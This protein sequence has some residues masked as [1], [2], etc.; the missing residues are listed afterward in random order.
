MV[1]EKELDLV[2]RGLMLPLMEEFYTIQGEGFHKGTAAYFIRVGGCDVG[3]HW[4]DVKESWDA[5]KHPPTSIEN[6]V[7][8]AAKYSDTIVV[9]GGEPLMW[10]MEPLT[11][12]LKANKLKTHI[13]TS[14][15]YP[16]TGTWD[17][18]CLSPK[19]TKLPVSE[20]YEVADELK[21]IVYNR[22]DLV[23]AEEQAAQV[24]E[25]CVLYLQPEWSVRDKVIPLIVDY[26]MQNPKWKVSLQTHKY[27]NIP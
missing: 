9:T 6:I 21:V 23:F 26:V 14:G 18:V 27:L 25:N 5:E 4:C 19:K 7:S 24:N 15:A 3:C 17:W 10:N 16:L 11:S 12:G 1:E 22:H 13:E 2:N 20:V 8:N